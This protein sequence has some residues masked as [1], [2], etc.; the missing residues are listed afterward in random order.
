MS[1]MFIMFLFLEGR[2][3]EERGGDGR[4]GEGIGRYGTG[5]VAG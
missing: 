4:G 1:I 2:G 5:V 3:G